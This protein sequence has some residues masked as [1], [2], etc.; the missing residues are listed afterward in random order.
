MGTLE[1]GKRVG[2][3][4]KKNYAIEETLIKA[5]ILRHRQTEPET[6]SKL[7]WIT[8]LPPQAN[9]ATSKLHYNNSGYS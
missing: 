9:H 6:Y 5:T 3:K 7:L 2:D 8:Q 1:S 4:E